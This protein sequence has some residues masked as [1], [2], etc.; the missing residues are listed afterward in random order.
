MFDIQ[1]ETIIFVCN[2][3]HY[4]ANK[5][6]FTAPPDKNTGRIGRGHQTDAAPAKTKRRAGFRTKLGQLH[7]YKLKRF[8][9]L[10]RIFPVPRP[11]VMF[12]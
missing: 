8:Y 11:V 9:H 4:E 2:I 12:A 7:H 3:K 1:N 10:V 6:Y 5:I